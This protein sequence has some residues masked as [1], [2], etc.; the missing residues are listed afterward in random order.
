MSSEVSDDSDL[1]FLESESDSVQS[2]TSEDREFIIS[3]TEELSYYSDK[4]SN[5]GESYGLN[6]GVKFPAKTITKRTICRDGR[7]ETQYLVL[8]YS[9]EKERISYRKECE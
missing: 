7:Q 2:E 6:I 5:N 3:D 9:W 8:W 4:S 1:T